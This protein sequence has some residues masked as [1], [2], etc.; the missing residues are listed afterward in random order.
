MMSLKE[1]KVIST[2]KILDQIVYDRYFCG[3]V[4]VEISNPTRL[5]V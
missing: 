4:M 1:N 3:T 2:V 5:G